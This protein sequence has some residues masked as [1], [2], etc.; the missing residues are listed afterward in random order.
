MGLRARLTEWLDIRPSEFRVLVLSILGAFLVMGFSV[1]AAALR[2]AFYIGRFG[3]ENLP[4][5]LYA[6]ILLGLP[7]VAVFSRLMGSRA[8]HT[9]MRAVIVLASAG[10]LLLYF[11]VVSPAIALDMRLASVAFY[12]WTVVATLL[13]TSGFWIIASDLFVVREA[14]RLFGLISAGGAL[15]A[16][17]SGVS[18]SL[19]LTRF[20]PIHLVPLLVLVLVLALIILELIPRDRLGRGRG[21]SEES[22]PPAMEGLRTLFGNRHLRLVAGIVLVT[23]AAS[24]IVT[25]QLQE[26]IEITALSEAAAANL[27]EGATITAVNT[28]IAAFMGAFRGWTGGLAFIIQV[29]LASRILAGAG[30]AWSLAILPLALI[31]GSTGM[32]VLPGLFM[33]TLVR[34]ADYALGKSLYRTV[35]ELLWVPV[36]SSLRRRA[37]AFVDTTVG[38]AG[39]GLG[40]LIVLLWV[41]L[42]HLPSRFLSVFVILACL[43]LLYLS[44]AM[45][46]QYFATL[47]SR[48]ESS[49]SSEL[50]NAAGLE[51]ADRLGATFTR[52]DITRVLATTG[53]HLDAPPE[54]PRAPDTSADAG[55]AESMTVFQM[56]RT[57]DSTLIG[58]ALGGPADWTVEDVPTLTTFLARD[59]WLARAVHALASV[60]AEAVPYLSSVLGDESA[61]FVIRRRIPRVLARI[62]HPDADSELMD[63]LQ[64]GRFEVRYRVALALRSRRQN[65]FPV[66]PGD[67]E[68]AIWEAIRAELNREKPVWELARLLDAEADDAFVENRIGLRGELSLEHTFRMLSLV[69]EHKTTRA[70]YHGIVLDDPELKSFAL[71][72]L[73][74]ALPVDVRDRL[75][76]FIGDL[77]ASA[78][79]RA[80]RALD[81]VV[82]DLLQT[83]ATLFG[84]PEDREALRRY[85][86]E[87]DEDGT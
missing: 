64:A 18:L 33:A 85:L 23:S 82:A 14:K 52:L 55:A 2:E 24:Y 80:I 36:R 65:S 20:R 1:V 68:T 67:R 39:D 84:S 70:A 77:S 7:A 81:D 76:P 59:A 12:L 9:V 78:A 27:G 16:L 22:R 5:I 38:N 4:Y 62:D 31:L 42:G 41:T 13:L 61:D 79:R 45:G 26:A 30:I 58:E 49:S 87:D 35:A 83:G 28:R 71:E 47:R 72:Y 53:I 37:K 69:L 44:R 56:I 48:L 29:F 51:R 34:G 3:S 66:A 8:P 32:L 63:A 73:E 40:A 57:G 54:K 75:W 43:A 6:S 25:W 15:G 10:L 21:E 50:L 74:Q 86:E 46:A 60:G 19:L 11:L 17:A